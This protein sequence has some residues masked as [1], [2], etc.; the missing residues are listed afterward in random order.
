VLRGLIARHAT[1]TSSRYAARLLHDIN[2]TLPDFWQI[3]PKDYV[4]YL[5]VPLTTDAAQPKRA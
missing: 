5:P 4:K 3:V 2:R 1:E